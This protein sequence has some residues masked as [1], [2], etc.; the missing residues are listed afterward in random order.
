MRPAP[1]PTPRPVGPADAAEVEL[2]LFRG[3]P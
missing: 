3:R 2:V 1:A